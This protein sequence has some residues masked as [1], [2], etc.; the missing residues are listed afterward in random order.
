MNPRFLL[1]HRLS[2]PWL[3]LAALYTLLLLPLDTGKTELAQTLSDACHGPLF[4]LVAI[5][6]LK[7]LRKTTLV[8][9]P[10]IRLYLKALLIAM[11]LGTLGEAAQYLFTTT[12]Y[13]QAN[14]VLTDTLG[15]IAGLSWFAQREPSLQSKPRIKTWLVT[16]AT[17]SIGLIALPVAHTGIF[18]FQRWQQLPA[19]ITLKSSAGYHFLHTGNSNAKLLN[20]PAPWYRTPHEIALLVS[21][22]SESR[23][24]GVTLEEPTPNWSSYSYLVV[25]L[26]NPNEI[27][28]ELNL[29]IDD[30]KH[31]QEFNDRFNRKLSI[32]AQTR[33]SVKISLSDIAQGPSTRQLDTHKI[34]KLVLFEDLQLHRLPFYLCSM[35]LE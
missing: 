19:L 8:A 33:I 10:S 14:D 22:H 13:A 5:L 17:I 34:S 26:I 24:A 28:L 6:S 7:H 1:A 11:L 32:P 2:S 9:E 18:Y 20:I 29:R 16:A 21:P 25:K 4:A 23:W 12:R 3:G 31:N 30:R 15:A 27:P 35:R